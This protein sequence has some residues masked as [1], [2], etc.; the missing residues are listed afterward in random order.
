MAGESSLRLGKEAEMRDAGLFDHERLK[1]GR[2]NDLYPLV[3]D[4]FKASSNVL[5]KR[6]LVSFLRAQDVQRDAQNIGFQ[7][8][9]SPRGY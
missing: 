9:L 4:N 7:G 5:V 6:P 3:I 2:L 8:A 1:G